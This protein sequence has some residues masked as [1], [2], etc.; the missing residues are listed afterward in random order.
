MQHII[1]ATFRIL[2]SS[3]VNF[4]VIVVLVT[5]VWFLL[6][7]QPENLY[8]FTSAKKSTAIWYHV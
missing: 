4:F 7:T 5:K 8:N 2:F 3:G 6:L 1:I